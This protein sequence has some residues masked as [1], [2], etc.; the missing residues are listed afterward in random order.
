[1]KTSPCTN[2]PRIALFQGTFDPFTR[3]HEDI[4]K[5][6]LPLFDGIVIAVVNNADKHTLTSLDE[7]KAWI[8][9]V[10]RDEPRVKVVSSE[11][12][13]V[14]VARRENAVCL[15]RATRNAVDFDYERNMAQINREL[16]GIETLIMLCTPSLAHVSS[17]L[18][19]ELIAQHVDVTP[20]LP[21]NADLAL[22]PADWFGEK[23]FKTNE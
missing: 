12:L 8:Q 11:G 20:L 7:R 1:M 6:A 13:T 15:L 10:F 2:Q 14:D 22:A 3:G 19:R 21:E 5:R 23:I 18:V 17:S 16:S 9:A 4:V